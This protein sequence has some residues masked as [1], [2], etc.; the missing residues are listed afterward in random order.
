MPFRKFD[1]GLR[2]FGSTVTEKRLLIEFAWSDFAQLF[3]QFNDFTVVEVGVGIV[4]ELFTL[5][6]YGF[7][8]FRMTVTNVYT[9]DPRVEV[10]VLVAI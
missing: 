4:E 2:R 1:R 6:S 10:D 5:A 3:S 8:N 7:D 9:S